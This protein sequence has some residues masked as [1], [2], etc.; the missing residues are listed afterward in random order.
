MNISAQTTRTI[1]III[2]VMQVLVAAFLEPEY[3]VVLFPVFVGFL[4]LYYYKETGVFYMHFLV[5]LLLNMIAEIAYI[6]DFVTYFKLA[7]ITTF[8][9]EL[10]L[11]YMLKPYLRFNFKKISKHN[12]IELIIGFVGIGALVIYMLFIIIPKLPN[13]LI[14]M[15]TIISFTLLCLLC[16]GIPMLNKHPKHIYLWAV[17]SLFIGELFMAFIYEYIQRDTLFLIL[18]FV[19]GSSLKITLAIYFA[20]MATQEDVDEDY[21]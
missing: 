8:F 17:G 3:T 12:I 5:Y 19:L 21:I 10:L 20:N 15:P 4:V 7:V 6:Y 9:A 18:A 2:A 13:V 1:V 14:F 11:I 16:F